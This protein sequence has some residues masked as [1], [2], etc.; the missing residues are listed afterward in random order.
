[1][2]SIIRHLMNSR[3]RPVLIFVKKLKRRALT[4]AL[5]IRAAIYR[6]LYREILV[7]GDSH[8]DVFRHASFRANFPG[9]YFH[10]VCVQGATASGLENPNSKTQ[11]YPIFKRALD[12]FSGTT[13]VTLLGEVDTGFVIWYRSQKYDSP[14]DATLLDT[15]KTYCR[16]LDEIAATKKLIC[17]SAPLPTI[18]D[19]NDWGEIANLRKEIIANQKERTKLTLA[20]NLM[21]AKHCAKNKIQFINLDPRSLADD[22]LVRRDL[23]HHDSH[24][25]HYN[26]DAYASLIC[27]TLKT[28]IDP[29]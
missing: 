6:R 25:H 13:V 4:S 28:H 1:M 8:S 19:D 22:G 9:A 26:E 20:F 18:S 11:A 24:N 15:V 5:F 10:L 7:L 3:L 14:V 12:N 27:E 29:S 17:L 23:M 21:V 16:F 2:K